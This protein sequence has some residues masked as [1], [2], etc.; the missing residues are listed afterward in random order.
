MSNNNIIVKLAKVAAMS[1]NNLIKAARK[2]DYHPVGGVKPIKKYACPDCKGVQV[3][4]AALN[5]KAAP[6]AVKVAYTTMV[7]FKHARTGLRMLACPCGHRRMEERTTTIDQHIVKTH[8]GACTAVKTD[9]SPCTNKAVEG[10]A[11]C[12]IAAH[13]GQAAPPATSAGK[14][15]C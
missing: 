5:P 12:G 6:G 8:G 15:S 10:T 2:R 11:F 13:Q 14:P 7:Q 1:L 9:G 3:A 4:R